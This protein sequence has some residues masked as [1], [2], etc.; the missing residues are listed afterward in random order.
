MKAYML[1]GFLFGLLGLFPLLL[2]RR[3]HPLHGLFSPQL[4]GTP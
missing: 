1:Q 3:P 4:H 2:V